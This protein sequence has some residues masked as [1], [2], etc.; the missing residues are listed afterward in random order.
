MVFYAIWLFK[1]FLESHDMQ[2]K[3]VGPKDTKN[4]EALIPAFGLPQ[5]YRETERKHTDLT[6][7]Q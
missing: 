1:I 6:I 3:T 2:T 7:R 4:K 5:F